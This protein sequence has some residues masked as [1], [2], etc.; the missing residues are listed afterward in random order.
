MRYMEIQE[1][2]TRE[3][4]QQLADVIND[5]VR[6]NITYITSRGRRLAAVVPLD[7]AQK[8]EEQARG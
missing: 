7:V 3:V 5:A 1:L 6:G 2:G 8:A 4:R